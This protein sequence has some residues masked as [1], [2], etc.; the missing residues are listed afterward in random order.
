MT[1]IAASSRCIPT[2]CWASSIRSFE[3]ILDD[4]KDAKGV[5][6]DTDLDAD[7]LKASPTLQG[8][9][10]EGTGKAFPEDAQEQLWGAIGAVFGSWMNP[11][12]QH[13]SPA[14]QH[15]RGL[16]HG[17]HGAGDG[18]RQSRRD[19]GHRRRLHPRSR[20]RREAALRRI[21]DQRPGRRRGGRH[22]HAAA[23]LQD[24]E[25]QGGRKP[26][27]KAMPKAFDELTPSATGWN[28]ITATCRTS[29]SRSRKASSSCCRPAP[30]SARRK[31]ALRRGGHG[32]RRLITKDDAVT[33]VDA[34]GA[35]PVA[36]SH[37]RSRCAAGR[38]IAATG[39]RLARRRHRRSRVHRG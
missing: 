3:E 13:L 24:R 22:P 34:G 6:L 4:E 39:L 36:A 18:V 16:G 38:K 23:D 27:W 2:W 29:N 28:S 20:H 30:A 25:R 14:Q 37:P 21:P 19:L 1:A 10:E 26:R 15:S 17:G 5:E 31:P 8:A 9:G 11:A 35:R 7:D 33:R 12:R 32:A